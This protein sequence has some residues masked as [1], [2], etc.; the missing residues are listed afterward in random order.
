MPELNWFMIFGSDCCPTGLDIR[1]DGGGIQV[2]Q[3][4][5]KLLPWDSRRLGGGFY[6]IPHRGGFLASRKLCVEGQSMCQCSRRGHGGLW[7]V[8]ADCYHSELVLY[9]YRLLSR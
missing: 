2:V 9:E 8:S 4:R 6:A 1:S 3:C 7:T 5:K